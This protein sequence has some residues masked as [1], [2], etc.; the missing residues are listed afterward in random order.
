MKTGGKPAEAAPTRT[1]DE[2]YAEENAR[3]QRR[4]GSIEWGL[5]DPRV[6]FQKTEADMESAEDALRQTRGDQ[7]YAEKENTRF[8]RR[9]SAVERESSMTARLLC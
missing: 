3:F 7:A 9:L 5:T 4:V 8:H 6:V 2:A 1:R